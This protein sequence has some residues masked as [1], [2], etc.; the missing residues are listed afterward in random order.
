MT[1][2]RFDRPE[3]AAL[4]A[5]RPA[6]ASPTGPPL[7]VLVVE[8]NP[9]AAESLRILLELLGHEVRVARTGIEGVKLAQEWAPAVVL[10]DIGLPGLDGFG[11]A[12]ALRPSG[13]RLIAITGYA[14]QDFRRRAYES[15]YEEVLIKPADPN[16]L[17]RLLAAAG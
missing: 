14:G 2:I 16:V 17:V 5:T 11:V 12:E 8:D 9:D 15:G 1:S 4:A 6:P 7:R 13:A 10:S 3:P